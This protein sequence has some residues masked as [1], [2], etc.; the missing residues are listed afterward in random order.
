MHETKITAGKRYTVEY[1]EFSGDGMSLA[2]KFYETAA[3]AAA[4]YFESLTADDRCT[5]CRSIYSVSDEGNTFTV[6]F[7]MIMRKGGR[8]CGEK[9][10]EHRWRRWDGKDATVEK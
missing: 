4:E 9:T 2:N 1:P 6:R 8:R 5:V 3:Q 7:T 10:L